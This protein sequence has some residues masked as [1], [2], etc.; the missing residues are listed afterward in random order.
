MFKHICEEDVETWAAKDCPPPSALVNRARECLA[1][2]YSENDLERYDQVVKAW[3]QFSGGKDLDLTLTYDNPELPHVFASAM[4]SDNLDNAVDAILKRDSVFSPRIS[5]RLSTIQEVMDHFHKHKPVSLRVLSLYCS[6]LHVTRAEVLALL[7]SNSDFYQM[8]SESVSFVR[9]RACRIRTGEH[10]KHGKHGKNWRHPT[11]LV[12]THNTLKMYKN[13]KVVAEC[14]ESGLL[15]PFPTDNRLEQIVVCMKP[16][17][18]ACLL[19]TTA[20]SIRKIVDF[21]VPS[22][23]TID[24]VDVQRDTKSHIVYWGGTDHM[25]G[26]TTW[27]YC[28]GVTESLDFFEV[29]ANHADNVYEAGKGPQ[30]FTRHGNILTMHRSFQDV[31]DTVR[32]YKGSTSILS[33]DRV[34]ADYGLTLIDAWGTPQNYALLMD[35]GVRVYTEKDM[36]ETL[37]P[38]DRHASLC[39]LYAHSR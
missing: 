36:T 25:L 4:M 5:S 18:N 32:K 29:D 6:K 21:D 22:E 19:T 14:K 34:V 20:H 13:S 27:Q 10:Y 11:L 2:E 15:A 1:F 9:G 8:P 35:N 3:T 33:D 12:S 23:G 37:F 17:G 28:L 26:G 39:V 7:S 30:D 16:S 38:V 31:E 24:W